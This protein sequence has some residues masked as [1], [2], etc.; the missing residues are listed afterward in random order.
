MPRDGADCNTAS[1]AWGSTSEV[2][3]ISNAS[4]GLVASSDVFDIFESGRI[5]VCLI[6]NF[7]FD[8]TGLTACCIDDLHEDRP[9]LKDDVE[10]VGDRNGEACGYAGDAVWMVS[11]IGLRCISS[12]VVSLLRGGDENFEDDGADGLVRKR[13]MKN[14]H[15]ATAVSAHIVNLAAYW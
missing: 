2:S 5:G 9:E 15:C 3:H 13:R 1:R 7:V 11:G 12:A 10:C 6:T 8:D 4:W 14:A